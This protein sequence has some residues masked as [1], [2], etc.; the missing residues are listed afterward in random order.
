[1]FEP[2]E[3]YAVQV[4]FDVAKVKSARALIQCALKASQ[5]RIILFCKNVIFKLKE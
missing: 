4:A 3:E 1:L 5:M 2:F